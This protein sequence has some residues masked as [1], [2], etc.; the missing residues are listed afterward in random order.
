MLVV[1]FM[2]V[3]LR[4]H[5]STLLD[6]GVRDWVIGHR[7]SAAIAFFAFVSTVGSVTPI[8]AYTAVV[9]LATAL[10]RRSMRPL[11]GLAACGMA[12]PAYL[13]VKSLV[14]RARPSGVG[15]A[16]EGTYSFPSAHATTSSAV[17]CTLAYLLW[18]EHLASRDGAIL[19][20]SL[21]PCVIGLSRVYLDVHWTTDVLGG[22]CLG[23]AIAVITALA[24]EALG[25]PIAPTPASQDTR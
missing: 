14:L 9:L 15:N 6:Y 23:V 19:I 25:G 10:Y 13:G 7:S 12:V 18:R 4:V 8:I 1:A 22:W 2:G 5:P 21:A 11:A 17:C 16:F 20:A 24:Y 3:F